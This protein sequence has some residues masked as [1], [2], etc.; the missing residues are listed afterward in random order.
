MLDREPDITVVAQAQSVASGRSVIAARE[1]DN[2]IDV[3]IVDLGLPDGNG[4]EL[5]RFLHQSPANQRTRILVLTAETNRH[6]V[7]EAV[8][9]GADAILNKT[10]S[11]ATIVDAVRRIQGGEELLSAR[12]TIDLLRLA[13]LKRQQDR[14][15]QMILA[16]LTPRERDVL[17]SLGLGLSD[18][19]IGEHLN[20][21]NQTVRTHMVNLLTKLQVDSRL[22]ALVFAIKHGAVDLTDGDL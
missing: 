20:I 14:A 15:G 5:I 1:S 6:R 17:V 16:S 12:E 7:A 11:L 19:E 18:R 2:L 21:S 8:E 10:V 13:A 3:A 9:A 4:V 22:Q